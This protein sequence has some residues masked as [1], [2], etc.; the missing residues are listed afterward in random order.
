MSDAAAPEPSD[1]ERR[2][3]DA[4][5][6][7]LFRAESARLR[8]ALLRR[9]GVA[10][11][12]LVEDVVQEALVAA[13]IHWRFRGVPERPG[14]WLMR[15]AQRKAIDALRRDRRDDAARRAVAA[16]VEPGASEADDPIRLMFLCCDPSLGEADRTMLTLSLAAGFGVEEIARAFL[17]SSAAAE[18]RIV[19]AKRTLRERGASFELPDPEDPRLLGRVDAV[20]DTLYLMLNEAYA[21]HAGDRLLRRE[22]LD[23]TLRLVH[24][25]LA[26]ELLSAKAR[27]AVHALAALVSFHAAR[28]EARVD[29][30]GAIVLLDEQDRSVW[31]RRL[32][33][34]GFGHLLG[35]MEGDRPTAHG[36]EAAIAACHI[37]APSFE[38]TDW[39]R[40]VGLYELLGRLKPT[41]IVALNRAAAIA[42]RD[43]AEA[44]LAELDALSVGALAG[45]YHLAEATRGALLL[46]AG[47][48][49]EAA[50]ALRAALA[51]PCSE[52]E[53]ALLRT[54]LAEA[55]G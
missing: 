3:A 1:A 38:E 32:I 7:R 30:V 23:E 25:L 2:S 40:I 39:A 35:S 53:R 54:R 13:L 17:L 6:D 42:M 52:P 14:A 27:P 45:R 9:L 18:Q 34:N 46:R 16:W 51:L 50:T 24:M 44:G 41:P 26:S 43:G 20:L 8:A 48:R 31:D 37:A 11:L 47:R 10:R 15:V 4:L 22:L 12:E 29:G 21:A 55:E 36:L 19:R 28:S 33:A 5:A 49:A